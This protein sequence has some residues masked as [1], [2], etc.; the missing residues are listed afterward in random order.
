[1]ATAPRADDPG[2]ARSR[3]V[4]RDLN[5]GEVPMVGLRKRFGILSAKRTWYLHSEDGTVSERPRDTTA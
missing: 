2:R 4:L 1:M 5:L 3:E